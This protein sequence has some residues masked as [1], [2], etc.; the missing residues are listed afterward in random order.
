MFTNNFSFGG[1]VQLK[2]FGSKKKFRILRATDVIKEGDLCTEPLVDGNPLCYEKT[3][4]AF[5]ELCE[6]QA[7]NFTASRVIFPSQSLGETPSDDH[8]MRVYLRPLLNF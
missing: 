3:L 4:K 2:I 7:N 6:R 1:I 5:E 8:T